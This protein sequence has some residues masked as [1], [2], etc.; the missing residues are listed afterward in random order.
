MEDLIN[1]QYSHS[2]YFDQISVEKQVD[3]KKYQNELDRLNNA[4]IKG[5]IKEDYYDK[6]YERLE[7]IINSVKS[8]APKKR[9]PEELKEI[10]SDDWKKKY[11]SIDRKN[12]RAFF[13]GLI[14][15]IEIN[16]DKSIKTVHF[17]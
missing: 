14:E 8:E 15:K 12:K 7:A 4:Y 16:T 11:L 1:N 13:Q 10:L 6:E 2:V 3:V 9:S 5:R 17:K